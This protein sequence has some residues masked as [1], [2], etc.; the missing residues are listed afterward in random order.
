MKITPQAC[1]RITGAVEGL[2]DPGC[3][4]RWRKWA[5]QG[6]PSETRTDIPYDVASI[7]LE[8]LAVDERRIEERLAAEGLDE[9]VEADLLND[10]GYIEAIQ[11]ALRSEGIGRS[12]G[13]RRMG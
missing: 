11:N 13:S 6:H 1:R 9:D 4:T 8:A 12:L 2:A 10:L 5:E 3:K 7:A